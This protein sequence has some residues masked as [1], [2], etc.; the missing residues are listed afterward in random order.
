ML[1]ES[2]GVAITVAI[3]KTNKLINEPKK[4]CYGWGVGLSQVGVAEQGLL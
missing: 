3:S 2:F 4:K 1:S